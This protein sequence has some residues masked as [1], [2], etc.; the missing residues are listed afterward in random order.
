MANSVEYGLTCDLDN[1]V[2]SHLDQRHIPPLQGNAV[3][4]LQERGIG[5]EGGI[6]ELLSYTEEKA[7][8]FM[9]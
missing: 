8:N 7:I 9:L 3:R 6:E 2:R 1:P 4:R 5:R